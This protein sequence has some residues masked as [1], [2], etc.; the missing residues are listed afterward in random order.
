MG[1]VFAELKGEADVMYRHLSG[2]APES[3][4]LDHVDTPHGQYPG[5]YYPLIAHPEFEGPVRKMMGK[6]AL[7]QDGFVRATTA[8]GYTK[9]RTGAT[10]PLALDLDM[11]APRMKQM[12][13][14]IAM[15]PAVINASKIFYDKDIRSNVFTRFGAEWRD[16]MIPY[17]VDVANSANYMPKDQR[18][19]AN[20]SEFL[21]QNLITTL[22]GLNP[23][24]VLKHGP[25]ALVQSLHEV[26]IANFLKSMKSLFSINDRTGETN[27]QF[28][29]STSEELQRRHQNY[30]ETLGGASDLLQPTSGFANLRTTVQRFSASPVAISD[31]L[32]AVPTWLAQYEKT[33]GEGETHG[34]A[35]YAADRAVRRAHGSVA[36]TN[37]SSVMRGGALSQWFS[38][39]YGFFNHIMNRQYELLWKSGEAL[40]LAKSGQYGEA[41][42]RAPELTSMLFAYVLAP[43]LI[44]ELVTPLASSD[45]E[46]WGKKAA[47]G[48]AYTLGASWVGIR[49]VANA[50]LNGRDPSI[51]LMQT[52]AKSITDFVRDLS[53]QG[54]FNKAH[55]GKVVKDG[56]T[57]MGAL[58]GV[59][60]AQAGRVAQF[61]LGVTQGTERPKGPWGWLVGS[62]F[63][64]LRNHPATFQDYLRQHGVR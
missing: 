11:L 24:T 5:W 19:F 33:V 38:S 25:T 40:D 8:N 50:I 37:R 64:T 12:I 51:G 32:S 61:G 48:V 36:I 4:R 27:W 28:A 45:N 20:A 53:K 59:V 16:M 44:E 49:D 7:E 35:V 21:R 30:V 6:D 29:M 47:K 57:L 17:L 60:P 2:V 39:V 63:G 9:A 43:A 23:G 26:G 54:P 52:S 3:I 55:A 41:M 62:R 15:R 14:D 13:H 58:T 56:A 42:S 10:Y 1:N 31:L 34:D 18:L 46:S 22:V